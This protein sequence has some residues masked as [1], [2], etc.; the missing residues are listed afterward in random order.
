MQAV[1]QRS[2]YDVSPKEFREGPLKTIASHLDDLLTLAH[3]VG[4]VADHGFI[5]V[6]EDGKEKK[7]EHAILVNGQVVGK[8]EVGKFASA[9]KR[10]ILELSKYLQEAKRRKKRPSNSSTGFK[11]PIYVSQDLVSFFK[12][13]ARLGRL[14]H[15][16]TSTQTTNDKGK[17]VSTF[18]DTGRNLGDF[19]SLL[20]EQGITSPGLLTALFSIYTNTT[21]IQLNNAKGEKGAFIR[22]DALMNQYFG[23]Y[24][25]AVRDSEQAKLQEA[26]EKSETFK[27]SNELTVRRR[28]DGTFVK[29]TRSKKGQPQGEVETFNENNFRYPSYQT[30]VKVLRVEDSDWPSAAERDEAMARLKEASVLGQLENERNVVSTSNK[31]HAKK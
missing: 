13:A 3:N 9:L 27:N 1:E 12:E 4:R 22:A 28:P 8:R 20:L 25:Q 19:L 26:F 24:W 11:N 17:Q 21:G 10:E 7:K 18:R 16:F 5:M 29:L 14:G 2:R 31:A 23:Q 6:M 30:L 15:A